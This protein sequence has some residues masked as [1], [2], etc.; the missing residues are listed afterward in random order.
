MIQ[1][2]K[3]Y[4]RYFQ[5][6][7]NQYSKRRLQLR[8]YRKNELHKMWDG[9]DGI[10]SPDHYSHV[11]FDGFR[12]NQPLLEKYILEKQKLVN[13]QVRNIFDETP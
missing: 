5:R 3:V 13:R 8:E 4:K 7:Y 10:L 11:E 9:H 12:Y 1:K 6:F 2:L